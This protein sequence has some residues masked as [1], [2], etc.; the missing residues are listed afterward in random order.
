MSQENI[1]ARH[2]A[3]PMLTANPLGEAGGQPRR[4]GLRSGQT[5]GER[6]ARIADK[7][8]RNENARDISEGR[9]RRDPVLNTGFF[10]NF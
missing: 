4:K 8:F 6:Y 5:E 10:R 7:T 3:D 1:R 2:S 9:P